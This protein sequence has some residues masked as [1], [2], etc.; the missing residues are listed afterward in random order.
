MIT[1][2]I[3]IIISLYLFEILF[4]LSEIRAVCAPT[5]I[6]VW[7]PVEQIV[8]IQ[9]RNSYHVPSSK[10]NHEPGSRWLCPPLPHPASIIHIRIKTVRFTGCAKYRLS[11]N[12]RP[13]VLTSWCIAC[14]YNTI[15]ICMNIILYYIIL[16]FNYL[17]YILL[18]Y[19]KQINH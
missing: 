16:Y 15:I 14:H 13:P 10:R 19:I 3:I 18:K 17:F 12:C 2:V 5:R 6:N 9:R 1:R 8:C 4:D 7:R 11:C